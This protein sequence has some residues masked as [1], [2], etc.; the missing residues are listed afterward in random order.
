MAVRERL[1]V[2]LEAAGWDG[3]WYRR[4]YYD[5]GTP[6]GSKQGDECRIDGLAQAW[7]VISGAAPAERARTAM[8]AAERE[9]VDE[10]AGLIR[11]LTPAFRDTPHDPGYIKGYVAGVRENGGQYT[12]AALWFVRALAELD[13]RDR[14]AKLLAMLSPVSRTRTAAMVARY[15]TEPYVIAADMYG[16][17]PHVGRGGWSWY[18]GSAG[19]MLRVAVES[20]LGLT[21]SEGRTLVLRPRVPDEWP[22]FRIAWRVPGSRERYE[23]HVTNP[24]GSGTEVVSAKL[25]GA[26][27]PI[28]RGALRLPLAEDGATHR[29]EV[30]L[31]PASPDSG[32]GLPSGPGAG[33]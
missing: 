15:R 33:R 21:L 30:E 2:A 26:S 28:A 1:R 20:V 6:L 25:D 22:A 11:L 3:E 32:A 31:G 4:A 23:F 16:E 8:A 19:W 14:A 12:H 5:D 27:L 18:T 9:L 7:A 13:R 17:P 29:V 24:R 10:E